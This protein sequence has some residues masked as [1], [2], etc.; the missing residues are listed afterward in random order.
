MHRAILAVLV[1]FCACSPEPPD[2]LVVYNAVPDVL[3]GGEMRT[4]SLIITG[5]GR[6]LALSRGPDGVVVRTG[7]AGAAFEELRKALSRARHLPKDTAALELGVRTYQVRAVLGGVTIE[8]TRD[9]RQRVE[10]DVESVV[11]SL[12]AIWKATEP[13]ADV[14][15]TVQPFFADR[16]PRVRGWVAVCLLKVRG[17]EDAPPELRAAA[18][19]ALRDHL[20]VEEERDIVHGIRDVIDQPDEE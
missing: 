15:A 4:R 20:E 11:E 5:A 6:V 14:V 13:A 1:L 16:N 9:P 18:E 19:K 8:L 2:D 17:D 12:E 3:S 7:S 10:R